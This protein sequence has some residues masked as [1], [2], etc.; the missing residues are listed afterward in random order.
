MTLSSETEESSVPNVEM[1]TPPWT[2]TTWAA[3]AAGGAS[4]RPMP[5]SQP[6]RRIQLAV[7]PFAIMLFNR[8]IDR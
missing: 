4:T 7:T 8:S 3:D 6:Y 1:L 2:P 5:M